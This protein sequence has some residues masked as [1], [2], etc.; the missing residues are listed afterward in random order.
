MSTGGF[1]QAEWS[2]CT[3]I[4]RMLPG[5]QTVTYLLSHMFTNLAI[6]DELQL[7]PSVTSFNVYLLSEAVTSTSTSRW[8]WTCGGPLRASTTTS[9]RWGRSTW[10]LKCCAR[11]SRSVTV[12]VQW[13][14]DNV[15]LY[16]SITTVKFWDIYEWQISFYDTCLSQKVLQYSITIVSKGDLSACSQGYVN[17][18]KGCIS[19]YWH[20][21]KT[22]PLFSC[23]HNLVNK[24]SGHPVHVCRIF[25]TAATCRSATCSRSGAPRCPSSSS[26]T[27][28]RASAATS[29]SRTSCPSW[30]P[31]S[32]SSVR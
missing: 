26:C 11:S 2:P 18:N 9:C 24:Q 4:L 27:S 32:S 10:R 13:L 17:Q 28:P 8:T 15:T 7:W 14:L 1:E 25:E 3:S 20:Y 31:H 12:R 6:S 30:T 16:W 5:K 29:A 21:T 19:L 23:Q 22:Q